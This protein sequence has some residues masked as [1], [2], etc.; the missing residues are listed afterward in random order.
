MINRSVVF[1]AALILFARAWD[2][3]AQSPPTVVTM[4]RGACSS[5]LNGVDTDCDRKGVLTTLPNGRTIFNVVGKVVATIGFAGRMQETSANQ[6]VLWVDRAYINQS[7]V[8]A[9]GQCSIESVGQNTTVSC[10]AI[11][12]DGRLL[13]ADF[14]DAATEISSNPETTVGQSPAPD[15]EAT[16]KVH[17][18]LSRAQFQCGFRYYSQ[19][20][21]DNARACAAQLGEDHV[22]DLITSGMATFDRNERERGHRALCADILKKFPGIVRR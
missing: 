13:V 16:I 18:F 2:A 12:K 6:K 21:I 22:K 10:K 5:T 11:L 4:L 7:S 15:C 9:D 20:M 8:D 3:T 14:K 17:A 1:L 19:D